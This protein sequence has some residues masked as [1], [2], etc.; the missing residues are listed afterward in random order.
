M[1]G[2][3]E[4]CQSLATGACSSAIVAGTNLILSPS[5]TTS[6]S[7]NMVLSTSG[8]CRTFD[9]E[10]DGYGRGEAINALYLKPLG[11]AIKANDAIRA[12]IRS[13]AANSDGGTSSIAVPSIIAQEHLILD[14]YRR[15]N[16]NDLSETAFVECHGTGTRAGDQVETTAVANMFEGKEIVIGAVRG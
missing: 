3:H 13:T 4:A 1:V 7:G 11:D 15:G 6:M 8:V 10:A 14:A 9:A 5:M 2:I 16:I 12:I